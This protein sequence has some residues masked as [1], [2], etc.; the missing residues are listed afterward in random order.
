MATAFSHGYDK[1]ET[2]DLDSS[3]LGAGLMTLI[4]AFQI[5]NTPVLAADLLLRSPAPT[6]GS[7]PAVIEPVAGQQLPRSYYP[8]NPAAAAQLPGLTGYEIS[9]TRRKAIVV[10]QNLYLAWSGNAYSGARLVGEIRSRFSGRVVSLQEL[11]G[12]LAAQQALTGP[13]AVHVVGWLKAEKLHCFR[14]N[15][16]WPAEIFEA[17]EQVDG[18]GE[19]IFQ[20]MRAASART[21]V[22]TNMQ[23]DA[24]LAQ[25]KAAALI[26]RCSAGDVFAGL[27]AQKLSGYFYEI[28]YWDGTTFRYV[29]EI[30][31]S[32]WTVGRYTQLTPLV[33]C[34][35]AFARYCVVQIHHTASKNTFF[36]VIGD[37]TDNLSDVDPQ[38]LF[39][40]SIRSKMHCW[41]LQAI[42]PDGTSGQAPAITDDANTDIGWVESKN[43]I[44]HIMVN[45]KN[46]YDMMDAMRQAQVSAS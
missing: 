40:I 12:L 17:D 45:A 13:F 37:G 14:W 3:I 31:L 2:H 4:A 16:E 29:P 6:T 38:K 33:I 8:I 36:D 42:F 28:V 18:L 15:S 43:G 27:S 24:E 19:G 23:G 21:T 41:F 10:S 11:A 26:T 20:Q 39:P 5:E 22:K 32:F 34:Y 7:A 30:T 1:S 35:R 9:G 44:D 25:F 46:I